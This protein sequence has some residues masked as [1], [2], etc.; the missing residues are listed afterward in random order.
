MFDSTIFTFG[1]VFVLEVQWWRPC[2]VVVCYLCGVA[3][4][5]WVVTINQ[6]KVL[7]TGQNM[8]HP[9][10]RQAGQI[11]HLGDNLKTGVLMRQTVTQ[12]WKES[13]VSGDRRDPTTTQPIIGDR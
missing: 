10:G 12:E 7:E 1:H 5:W 13:L 2:V 9:Y 6:A 4:M 8:E 11:T 3:S